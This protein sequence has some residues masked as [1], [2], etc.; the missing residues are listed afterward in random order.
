MGD[1][2]GDSREMPARKN[3]LIDRIYEIL[4]KLEEDITALKRMRRQKGMPVYET[5]G[6]CD[7][8]RLLAEFN[9][10]RRLGIPVADVSKFER[11][12]GTID[13]DVAYKVA[14]RARSLLRELEGEIRSETTFIFYEPPPE[15][16]IVEPEPGRELTVIATKWVM[17]KRDKRE[18][19]AAISELIDE[20]L[21]HA[22][23]TNLPPDQRAMTDIERAQLIAIL[24][25]ALQI[26]K[27]PLVEKGLL[28]K[29]KEAAK[30]GAA[31][32]VRSGTEKALGY[33]LAKLSELLV[34]F[35]A[36]M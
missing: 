35:L 34:K 16:P 13:S 7:A 19:I 2:D 25:T 15:N 33:A 12:T 22:K 11:L 20:V 36:G 1:A 26:L 8:V 27:A 28:N 17:A 31:N 24:E 4:D 23:G 6:V 30:E 18:L 3:S 32:S 21:T 9:Y 29:A 14:S 10:D 5:P